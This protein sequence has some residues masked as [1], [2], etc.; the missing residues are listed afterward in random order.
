MALP[1]NIV[2]TCKGEHFVLFDS[3]QG[4]E[5]RIIVFGTASN[6]VRLVSCDKWFA[7]GTFRTVPNL[8]YQLY[9]IHGMLEDEIF[10][11]VYALLPNKSQKTYERFMRELKRLNSSLNPRTVTMD[12]ELAA[13][14]AF[15][16][17][18]LEIHIHGCFFHF[19]QAIMREIAANGLKKDYESDED[20]SIQMR[21][22]AALAFVSIEKVISSF[23]TL[24]DEEIFSAKAT[25]LELF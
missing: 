2:T 7:D 11:P 15:Q 6:L 5:D 24:I 14:N 8:F 9:S 12:I 18:F 25:C 10:P 19:G 22:L 3:G 16:A 4:D 1:S 13:I 20:F 23:E 17:V 21:M